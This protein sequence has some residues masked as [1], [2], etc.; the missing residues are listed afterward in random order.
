MPSHLHLIADAERGLLS[1][2]I[3]DFKSY[4]G[5]KMIAVIQEH[6]QES[7]KEWLLYLFSYFGKR[8]QQN[9]QHQFWQQNSH[10]IDLQSQHWIT[11]KVSYIHENPVKAGLVNEAHH[12]VFSSA[13]PQSGL[14]LSPL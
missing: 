9:A 6:P 3:R 14:L 12:W 13:N 8:N 7:R 11:Q 4:T 10:P 5:K 2:I 1:A